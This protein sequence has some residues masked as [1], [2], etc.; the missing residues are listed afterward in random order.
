MKGLRTLLRTGHRNE[1]TDDRSEE[2]RG[3][4]AI[5]LKGNQRKKLKRKVAA[6]L[7]F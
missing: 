3:G 7:A 1:I 5:G 2:T 6:F 4:P